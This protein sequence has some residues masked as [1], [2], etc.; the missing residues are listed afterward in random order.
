VVPTEQSKAERS[1]N[2]TT[3]FP[4]ANTAVPGDPFVAG[5]RQGLRGSNAFEDFLRNTQKTES[6]KRSTIKQ[7]AV[8]CLPAEFYTHRESS[9]DSG[10]SLSALDFPKVP[11]GPL[12]ALKEMREEKQLLHAEIATAATASRA[13]GSNVKDEV[14]SLNKTS[15]VKDSSLFAVIA[16][17]TTVPKAASPV[18]KFGESRNDTQLFTFSSLTAPV[19]PV[20]VRSSLVKS[21]ETGGKPN[22]QRTVHGKSVLHFNE[23]LVAGE[24]STLPC[25]LKDETFPTLPET[26][27]ISSIKSEDAGPSN[28]GSM[29]SEDG[30]N[31]SSPTTNPNADSLLRVPTPSTENLGSETTLPPAESSSRTSAKSGMPQQK[32]L[33][34]FNLDFEP[35]R[36]ARILRARSPHASKAK[37]A[38]GTTQ[39]SEAYHSF[40]FG[41]QEKSVP[42]KTFDFDSWNRLSSAARFPKILVF[43]GQSSET[44][45]NPESEERLEDFEDIESK[46]KNSRTAS[47]ELEVTGEES[48]P[49][50]ALRTISSN[51]KEEMDDSRIL[52]DERE[53][54]PYPPR[55]PTQSNQGTKG[56][57]LLTPETTP[58][59]NAKLDTEFA[60]TMELPTEVKS[61]LGPLDNAVE[62]KTEP[63]DDISTIQ[64]QS[65]FGQAEILSQT[66]YRSRLSPKPSNSLLTPP[67]SPKITRRLRSETGS[68][69]SSSPE[70][71]PKPSL[72]KAIPRKPLLASQTLPASQSGY[73][74]QTKSGEIASEPLKWENEREGSRKAAGRGHRFRSGAAKKVLAL[75]ERTV[76]GV[77]KVADSII[78][79]LES[80]ER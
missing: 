29:K 44:A 47:S 59:P 67:S 23:K 15:G 46:E 80:E 4:V 48:D 65:S 17:E 36:S 30:L 57:G 79:R 41:L 39:Q 69:T 2:R 27:Q 45:Q 74:T 71:S 38:K 19:A 31:E 76:S 56:N 8:P 62:F 52:K 9:T 24:P 63:T 25:I 22:S 68:F 77:S 33:P 10:P 50:A 60:H 37:E 12:A 64:K 11:D 61:V 7:E 70:T 40:S 5:E 20:N 21:T 28:V 51:I 73:L 3:N 78:T 6:H 58:Q 42:P 66:S 32:T 75:K 72:P 34:D 14:F 49:A 53:D 26:S 18:I 54:S 35:R 1:K 43:S 13:G 16:D 55:T